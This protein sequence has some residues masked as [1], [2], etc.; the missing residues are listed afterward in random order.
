[1]ASR[2]RTNV[3]SFVCDRAICRVRARVTSLL[4]SISFPSH[5]VAV[6]FVSASF[7]L[8]TALILD[9]ADDPFGD[10]NIVTV[11]ESRGRD[12]LPT[13]DDAP[14]RGHDV[15]TSHTVAPLGVPFGIE[16]RQ[17]LLPVTRDAVEPVSADIHADVANAD[18]DRGPCRKLLFQP[19]DG[20]EIDEK[21]GSVPSFVTIN[22][23]MV[24]VDRMPCD[25]RSWVVRYIRFHSFFVSLKRRHK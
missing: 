10:L 17:N 8:L 16:C 22:P 1:M 15:A 13:S 11:A 18:H 21:R 4:A 25:G 3:A 6:G 5:Q 9:D 2:F 24:F 20:A 12:I 7:F 14:S 23:A 19:D